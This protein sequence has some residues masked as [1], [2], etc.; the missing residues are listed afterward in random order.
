MDNQKRIQEEVDKTLN[1]LD[2]IQRA[3]ANPYLFTRIKAG[4]AKDEKNLWNK[5]LTFISRP[6]VALSAIVL[7]IF[8]NTAIFFEFRSEN[9]QTTQEAEQVFAS[10]YNL[11]DNTIYESMI[12]PNETI[13]TK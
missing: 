10:E 6:S 2:G 5:A 7:A 8:I 13:H 9:R 4:L 12:E 1:S 11:S 3:S